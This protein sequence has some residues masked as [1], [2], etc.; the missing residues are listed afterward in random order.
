MQSKNY[1]KHLYFKPNDSDNKNEINFFLISK[2]NLII[3]N[4]LGTKQIAINHK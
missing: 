3:L 1:S 2:Q 4:T